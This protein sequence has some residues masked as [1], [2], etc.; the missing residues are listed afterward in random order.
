[1]IA[2]DV[3][4]LQSEHRFRGVGTYTR[5]LALRLAE[6]YPEQ[7]VFIG[8]SQDKHLLPVP[9]LERAI[10][11]WRPH[12]PAQVYWVYNEWFLPHMIRRA[13]PSIFHATDFNGTVTIP[14]VRTVATLH[15][16]IGLI[17]KN[18]SPNL[19]GLLS[20]WRWK[21]YYQRKIPRSDYVIAISDQT[22]RDATDRLGVPQQQISV[23][24]HGIDLNH[25]KPI[26]NSGQFASRP[27]YVLYVGSRDP[28]KNVA[29]ALEAFVMVA[30]AIPDVCLYVAGRWKPADCAWLK[31]ETSARPEL[32][33][34][35]EHVGFVADDDMA[36]LYANA[37]VFLFPSLAEGFGLPIL[38]AMACHTPVVSS[39]RGS[40]PE[41]AGNA[42]V[43]CDPD[44]ASGL[45]EAVTRLIQNRALREDFIDRGSARVREFSWD[46]V[47]E[48][49]IAVYR[50][51]D[52]AAI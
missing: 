25:Y 44:D 47:L 11:S 18:L 49:T 29:G 39:N 31:A 17:S 23:I 22:Q 7:V 42:A 4:P 30:R 27:P 28:H 13:R 41:V 48:K 8:T 37:E 19:S 40:L 24:P 52:P 2:F 21:I 45:G 38:E 46:R 36:S 15:D 5:E 14:G 51:V 34:R 12:R 16:A 35:V 1:M 33:G 26:R 9:I 50:A 10:L 32:R 6:H 43:L 20:A 3:T